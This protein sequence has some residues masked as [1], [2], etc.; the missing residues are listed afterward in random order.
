MAQEYKGASNPGLEGQKV[1][2]E[3]Y[4]VRSVI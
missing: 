4:E 2:H 1:L 3:E